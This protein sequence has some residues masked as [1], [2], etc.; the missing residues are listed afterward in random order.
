MKL[1]RR[2]V[3]DDNFREALDRPTGDHRSPRL[4]L[5]EQHHG[6]L[7]GPADAEAGVLG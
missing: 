4:G 7:P 5:L 1:L 6:P 3:G 2:Y